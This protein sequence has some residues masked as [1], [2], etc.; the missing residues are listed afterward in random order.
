MKKEGTALVGEKDILSNLT[1][2]KGT[3]LFLGRYSM[4]EALAVLGK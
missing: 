2:E 1:E 4:T 3:S